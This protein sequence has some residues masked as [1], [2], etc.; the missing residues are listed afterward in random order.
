MG[1]AK[2]SRG[3]ARRP[4]KSCLALVPRNL[5]A[6]ALVASSHSEGLGRTS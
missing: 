2:R 6:K 4:T 1:A 3:A 5:R